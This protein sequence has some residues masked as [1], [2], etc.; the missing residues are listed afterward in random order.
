MKLKRYKSLFNEDK[1]T[2]KQITGQT[3]TDIKIEGTTDCYI[4]LSNSGVM[5]VKVRSTKDAFFVKNG[6]NIP[7]VKDVDYMIGAKIKKVY[8]D[9]A[10]YTL[11]TSKGQLNLDFP[12]KN[13]FITSPTTQSKTSIKKLSS[14][15]PKITGTY[16]TYGFLS[17]LP[18]DDVLSL[19]DI[20]DE[21]DIIAPINMKLL[22]LSEKGDNISDMLLQLDA[23][24]DMRVDARK[25][26]NKLSIS[27][28]MAIKKFPKLIQLYTKLVK[29]TLTT[30]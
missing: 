18:F 13:E 11:I 20:T 9:D 3:I 6:K 19:Y 12:Q 25:Y 28:P 22:D 17:D 14:N 15:E 24:G 4:T 30:I 10:G 8:I 5:Y 27:Y 26:Q 23:L 16:G 21:M 1:I 2:I 7:L 29:N